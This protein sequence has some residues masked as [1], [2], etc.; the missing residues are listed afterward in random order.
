MK[1]RERLFDVFV[2]LQIAALVSL[3]E[4]LIQTIMH[5]QKY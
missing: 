4:I 3:L 2:L 5:V 1:K